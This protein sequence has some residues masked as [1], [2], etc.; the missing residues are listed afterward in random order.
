MLKPL[1]ARIALEH[2]DPRMEGEFLRLLCGRPECRMIGFLCRDGRV[3]LPVRMAETSRGSGVW[4]PCR[5]RRARITSLSPDEHERCRDRAGQLYMWGP[6]MG[7]RVPTP[8]VRGDLPTHQRVGPIGVK[9][10]GELVIVCKQGHHSH[11]TVEH[12]RKEIA[13]LCE[14]LAMPA[15]L[16]S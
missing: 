4:R 7:T 3:L 16:I 13:R 11:L 2:H 6:G 10:P 9:T 15:S 14:A 1:M 12:A 5:V 8:V